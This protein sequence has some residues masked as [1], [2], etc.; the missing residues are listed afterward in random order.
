MDE[1]KKEAIAYYENFNP[2]GVSGKLTIFGGRDIKTSSIIAFVDLREPARQGFYIVD[3]VNTKFGVN[4]YRQEITL[5]YRVKLFDNFK[6][7]K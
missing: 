4:G 6:I 1:L 5:P 2:S 3:E 7:V